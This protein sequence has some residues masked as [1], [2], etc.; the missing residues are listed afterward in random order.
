MSRIVLILLILLFIPMV[1]SLDFEEKCYN[2]THYEK[3]T[4]FTSCENNTCTDYNFSQIY[5]CQFGCDNVTESCR[6][7]EIEE[8]G[9]YVLIFFGLLII[10]GVVIKLYGGR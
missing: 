10:I 3:F 1:Y 7:P 8:Y 5:E 4:E 6:K 9:L 2:T